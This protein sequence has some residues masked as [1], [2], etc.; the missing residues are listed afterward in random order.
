MQRRLFVA[1]VVAVLIA[2]IITGSLIMSLLR[3]NYLNDLEDKLL[4]NSKLIR[5]NIDENYNITDFD[6][7]AKNYSKEINTRISFIDKQGWLIGDSEVNIEIAENH[8]NREEVKIALQGRIATAKRYSKSLDKN[9]FYVAI[10]YNNQIAVIRLS[11]PLTYATEYYRD[12]F[13]Y[14]LISIG[15]GTIVAIFLGYRYIYSITNP[16]KQLTSATKSIAK[17]NYGEK[18]YY[19]SHDEIGMLANSFNIMSKKLYDN[20]EEL[21]ENSTKTKAILKSMINGIIAINNN[22]NIIFINPTAEKMFGLVEEDVRNKSILD[23]L[24]DEELKNEI[25]ELLESNITSKI[26]IEVYN[27]YKVLSVYTNIIVLDNDPTRKIGVVISFQ[28]ITDMRKLEIMRKDFVANV[29]HEL[30]TPLTSIQGF[31]ETLKNGEI[32]DEKVRNRFLDIIDIE[33]KRLTAL[34]KDLLIL[35]DIENK[36]QMVSMQNINIR[37]C[38]V[39]LIEMFEKIASKKNIK[40]KEKISG[41]L[42]SI[43]GNISWFKQIIINLIDNSIKYTPSG[44]KIEIIG[45]EIDDKIHIRVKDTGIG[46]SKEHISRLFERFY[47]VDKAR[48][49]KIGGTGLGLAIVKHIVIAFKGEIKVK[50]EVNKGTEFEVIIPVNSDNLYKSGIEE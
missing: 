20:I 2:V 1:L 50:S 21:K 23:I 48:S 27:P 34:I 47:R 7:L 13:K 30:K 40:I 38:I 41:G 8:F 16:I 32:K 14:I 4:T 39:D 19:T 37:K 9:M 25:K 10:P 22:N 35:S 33:S 28:D 49:R 44:G 6:R 17:G 29:S 18:V 5:Y 11:V 43:Y 15:F 46:I 12:I 24:S 26:E 3:I 36:H 45:Y 42:P 31:I